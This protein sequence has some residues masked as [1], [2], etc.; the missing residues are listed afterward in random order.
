MWMQLYPARADGSVP[1]IT[2]HPDD[3][4]SCVNVHVAILSA[5][6][7]KAY[8]SQESSTAALL[9]VKNGDTRPCWGEG[10]DDGRG[11]YNSEALCLQKSRY[12]CLDQGDKYCPETSSVDAACGSKCIPSTL[13]PGKWSEADGI[14][15]F[16]C[17]PYTW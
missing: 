1:A 13:Y 8:L 17:V 7:A 4:A 16:T 9:T 2:V 10:G 11:F 15:R 12:D 6:A 3:F 5:A 14:C